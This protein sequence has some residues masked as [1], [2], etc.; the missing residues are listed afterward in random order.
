LELNDWLTI[1]DIGGLGEPSIPATRFYT[2][3]V[4]YNKGWSPLLTPEFTID[5]R[6]ETKEN[7]YLSAQ[8]ILLRLYNLSVEIIELEDNETKV[9]EKVI[10]WCSDNIHPY[11]LNEI[12]KAIPNIDDFYKEVTD[13]Y[14]ST[15]S[16]YEKKVQK[17]INIAEVNLN[18][19]L[20]DL[21]DL[22]ELTKTYYGIFCF[23]DGNPTAIEDLKTVLQYTSQWNKLATN[24]MKE[25][26]ISQESLV[27]FA[28]TIP[29]IQFSMKFNV[30]TN[31][32]YIGPDLNSVFEIA[33]Y[34]LI[35]WIA[36][37]APN[38][39]DTDTRKTLFICEACGK[40]GVKTGPRQK[41]CAT[42]GCQDIRNAR[43][44]SRSK[45]KK[46]RESNFD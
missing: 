26:Q 2:Y 20:K 7:Y 43:K 31:N 37:N 14:A 18:E 29:S 22:Y 41:Y 3:Y 42:K 4:E 34:A 1:C 23:E 13:P 38:M 11:N 32:F 40:I 25:K 6:P 16:W 30:E 33:T 44:T 39:E 27:K 21:K 5:D 17:I 9:A 10:K 45:K 12:Y 24:I 19:F 8:D 36:S 28:N 35:R 46:G 15:R